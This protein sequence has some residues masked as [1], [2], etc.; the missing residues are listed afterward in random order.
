MG[1]NG[2]PRERLVNLDQWKIDNIF[3]ASNKQSRYWNWFF[4]S[5]RLHLR[6]Q[7]LAAWCDE[8]VMIHYNSKLN[9]YCRAVNAETF[10][11]IKHNRG[12]FR[13]SVPSCGRIWNPKLSTV[14]KWY[15][16]KIRTKLATTGTSSQSWQIWMTKF[17]TKFITTGCGPALKGPMLHSIGAILSFFFFFFFFGLGR[18]SSMICLITKNLPFCLSIPL[19]KIFAVSRLGWLLNSLVSWGWFRQGLICFRFFCSFK[20][21]RLHNVLAFPGLL[22]GLCVSVHWLASTPWSPV[23][24]PAEDL[25]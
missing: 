9:A 19:V 17:M 6:R 7:M 10:Q 16:R 21:Y 4:D 24:L 23:D 11:T 12:T 14:P 22:H 1:S 25:R 8:Y 15:S 3:W 5:L 2:I 20:V 13:R 18:K